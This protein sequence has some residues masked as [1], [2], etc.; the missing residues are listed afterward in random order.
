MSWVHVVLDASCTSTQQ[1]D[2][3]FHFPDR[4]SKQAET[5]W[6]GPRAHM[7]GSQKDGMRGTQSSRGRLY[8]GVQNCAMVLTT[9]V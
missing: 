1:G 7:R 5:S 6:F 9:L 2:L 3:R 8:K 4:I